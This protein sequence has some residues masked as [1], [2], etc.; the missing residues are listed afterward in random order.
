[1]SDEV[2][3]MITDRPQDRAGPG[4]VVTPGGWSRGPIRLTNAD[5]IRVELAKVYRAAKRGQIPTEVATRLT[6][7][8]GELRKAYETS[9]I[10]RRLAALESIDEQ[11]ARTT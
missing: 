4:S 3:D 8:L 1:M 2:V 5:E 7:I 10:E 9:V 6:Y 11:H